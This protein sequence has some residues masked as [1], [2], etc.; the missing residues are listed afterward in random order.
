MSFAFCQSFA[1]TI[2]SLSFRY[3]PDFAAPHV[4]QQKTTGGP[5]ETANTIPEKAYSSSDRALNA[6]A[7]LGAL[8]LRAKRAMISL[9]DS[10]HQYTLAESTQT[11]SSQ[12]DDVYEAGDSLWMG[13][14]T[15]PREESL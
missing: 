9:I 12:S 6:F 14:K 11:L 8:R 15:I 1:N 3:L 13:V 7:Q 2:S 10:K 5:Q 4:L